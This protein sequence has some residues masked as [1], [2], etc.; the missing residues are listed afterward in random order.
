MNELLKT[1]SQI[2]DSTNWLKDNG[3]VTHPISCKDWELCIVTQN[4]KDGDLLDAGA[5]GSFVL[6]NAIRKGIKGRK[7]GID[8]IEVVGDNATEGAEYF[9]GDLQRTGFED[10][11][12]DTIVSCSVLE[13]GI[14]F[15]DF[16]KE[17]NRI[18]RKDGKLYVS[19]DYAPIKIDTS[20]TKLYSLDWNILSKDD[21][22]KFINVCAMYGL[23]IS[24]VV[25]WGVQD[26]VI[27][28][29]YCSPAKNVSY[30]FGMF[31]FI[32]KYKIIF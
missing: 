21:A 25:D 20:L 11:S 1:K 2:T 32:H 26:M 17:M 12:F 23:V 14:D 16:A 28:D 30:T 5:D 9:K 15:T 29:S 31:Q 6:H 8:L 10:N 22:E 7:V 3:Y 4:L 24:D 27:N 13:H 18:L 19:F